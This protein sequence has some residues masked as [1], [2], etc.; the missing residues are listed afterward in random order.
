MGGREDGVPVRYPAAEAGG[1]CGALRARPDLTSLSLAR[2]FRNRRMQRHQ[3]MAPQSPALRAA[4]QQAHGVA[5]SA[6]ATQRKPPALLGEGNIT[7]AS[8]AVP[9]RDDQGLGRRPRAAATD[10]LP[11]GALHRLA[12]PSAGAHG[13]RRV[14]ASIHPHRREGGH[15]SGMSVLAPP[16]AEMPFSI[17]SNRVWGIAV[18]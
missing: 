9:K 1:L 2:G 5:A 4:V 3:G 18:G 6:V 16:R 14:D 12:A 8:G 15:R 11:P 17:V 10:P 7:R 13:T